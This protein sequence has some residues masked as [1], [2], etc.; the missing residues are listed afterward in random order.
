VDKEFSS[1]GK[2]NA[3]VYKSEPI[4]GAAASN[5]LQMADIEALKTRFPNEIT[6]LAPAIGDSAEVSVGRQKKKLNMRGVGGFYNTYNSME[7]LLGRMLTDE[8]VKK[9]REFI[10]IPE[11]AA[12]QLFG[13]SDVIGEKMLVNASQSNLNMTIVGVYK[14]KK[15]VFTSLSTD[16]VYTTFAPYTLFTNG[17]IG[18][19]LELYINESYPIEETCNQIADYLS[20]LKRE[21]PGSYRTET[22]AAQQSTIT[23]LLSGLSIAIGAIAAISLVVGGI[24]IMN[25]MLVSVTERTREIGIRKSLGAKTGDILVQFL[26]EAMIV[27][28]IG[29]LIGTLLGMSIAAIGLSFAGIH[30]HVNPAIVLMAVG[31]SAAVGMFFGLYPARKAARMNPIEALRYE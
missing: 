21:S 26:I 14:V 7:M 15:S 4:L 22:V 6:Y 5:P 3:Y 19:T 1:F 10:V 29:G 2:N 31:F 8:D 12:I 25:I 9:G 30:L 23:G 20:V 27:S 13:K 16:E 24:G 18:D 28:A 11:E 17:G